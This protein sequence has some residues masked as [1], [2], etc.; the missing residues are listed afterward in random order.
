VLL[1]TCA[2]IAR[3]SCDQ[4]NQALAA[5]HCSGDITGI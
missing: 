2:L 1:D 4:F 3:S 5:L